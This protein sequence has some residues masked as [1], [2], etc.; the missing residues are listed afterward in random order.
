MTARV[1]MFLKSRA[2]LTCFRDC[3][4]PGR[5]KDLSAPGTFAVDGP[6]F[7]SVFLY[8]HQNWVSYSQ[9]PQFGGGGGVLYRYIERCSRLR[10]G[11]LYQVMVYT[12]H[13]FSLL[14]NSKDSFWNF[15]ISVR[16]AV[17]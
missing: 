11:P 12:S 2:S 14:D 9:K 10:I 16:T 8:A 1:S 13:D 6:I 7:I 4:L 15:P 5:A 3:F 17:S